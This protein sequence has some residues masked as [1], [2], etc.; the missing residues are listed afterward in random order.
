MPEKCSPTSRAARLAF[1]NI[2]PRGDKEPKMKALILSAMLA[3]G[4]VVGIAQASDQDS[5]SPSTYVKDSIITTKVKAKLAA[6]P[7]IP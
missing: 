1:T 3:T 2:S 5:A 6:K 4:A 7:W